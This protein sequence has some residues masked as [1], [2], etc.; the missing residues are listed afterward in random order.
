MSPLPPLVSDLTRR[1]LAL[2]DDLVPGLV[3]GLY[4]TGSAALGDFHAG[5]SDVDVVVVTSRPPDPRECAALADVHAKLSASTFY[6][7][8]YVSREH[9]DDP[10]RDGETVPFVAGGTLRVDEPC[11]ELN[12]VTWRALRRHGRT[13]RG[14]DPADLGVPA[15]PDEVVRDWLLDNLAGY[16]SRFGERVTAGLAHAPADRVV[17]NATIEW[18]V[19][20]PPRLHYT[21]TT[22]DVVSKS[23]A[24]DHL[25]TRFPRWSEL[26]ERALTS[27]SGGDVLFTT[28]DLREAASLIEAVRDSAQ[29]FAA[30]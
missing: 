28:E 11:D 26:G 3:E 18:A 8:F 22:G 15:Q 4:V 24:A 2:V 10:P 21:L 20:G 16:W 19:L 1:H 27:R 13:V 17:E 12:P 6:D 7:G 29:A 14:V 23:G 25:A 30:S 9:L 5:T